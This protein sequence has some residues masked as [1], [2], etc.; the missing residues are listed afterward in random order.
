M[1]WPFRNNSVD[2]KH[3]ALQDEVDMLRLRI[4]DNDSAMFA[5]NF[6]VVKVF[7]IERNI[8]DKE[9]VTIIGYLLP[10]Q[11]SVAQ[12]WYWYCSFE[13]HQRLVE[14]FKAWKGKTK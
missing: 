11:P 4:A 3:T 1:V 14:S 9:P 2:P 12:E 7:S 5:F 10:D 8:E 6:D 13:E